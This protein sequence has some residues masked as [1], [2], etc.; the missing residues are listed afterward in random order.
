MEIEALQAQF[1]KI[2]RARDSVAPANLARVTELEVQISICR[3][4]GNSNGGKAAMSV[5]GAGKSHR[6]C[7]RT[8]LA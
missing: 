7:A 3:R 6:V 8:T 1:A 4:P 2:G 5:R